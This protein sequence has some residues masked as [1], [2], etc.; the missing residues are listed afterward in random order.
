MQINPHRRRSI[1]R[2]AVPALTIWL[3][4]GT[5]GAIAQNKPAR[6]H[7]DPYDRN[8]KAQPTPP[9]SAKQ[10]FKSYRFETV[11]TASQVVA[12]CNTTE[13]CKTLKNVCETLPQHDFATDETRSAGVCADTTRNS[14]SGAFFLRNANTAGDL[15]NQGGNNQVTDKRPGNRQAQRTKLPMHSWT[16]RF[17]EFALNCEGAAICLKVKNT[18]ATLGGTYKPR[19]DVSGS[20][21]H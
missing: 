1:L 5:Y 14:S 7:V 18:C 13:G 9:V 17:D 16:V 15:S 11:F 10:T 12:S 20:C 2:L 8:T 21:R 19:D 3:G 4:I 6:K